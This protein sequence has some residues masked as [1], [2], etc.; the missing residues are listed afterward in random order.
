M[1]YNASIKNVY[2]KDKPMWQI[3]YYCYAKQ[4]ELYSVSVTNVFRKSRV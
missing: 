1:Q 4:I 3:D 2:E